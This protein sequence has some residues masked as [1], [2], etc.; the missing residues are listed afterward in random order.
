MGSDVFR[1]FLGEFFFYSVFT[2]AAVEWMVIKTCIPAVPGLSWL[3]QGAFVKP[4]SSNYRWMSSTTKAFTVT[5]CVDA[6]KQCTI[7][8]VDY[9]LMPDLSRVDS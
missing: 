1:D 5:Q 3:L 4:T 7:I 8:G 2:I 6:F 9:V